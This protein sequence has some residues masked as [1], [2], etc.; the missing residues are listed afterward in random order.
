MNTNEN[1]SPERSIEII[2]EMIEKT[3]LNVA[4]SS[5][6][7]LIIWGCLTT[8]TAAAVGILWTLTGSPIWNLLWLAMMLI[9]WGYIFTTSIKGKKTKI[10]KPVTFVNKVL[11]YV[12]LTFGVSCFAIIA[13]NNIN[14]FVEGSLMM[15]YTPTIMLLMAFATTITALVLKLGNCFVF[16]GGSFIFILFS[17]WYPGS[18]EMF[19]LAMQSVFLLIIPGLIINSRVRKGLL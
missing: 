13:F 11:E 15:P 10:Q 5:G 7:P 3:R 14:S 16:I 17:M 9:G 12:W 1:L 19:C 18:Y 8:I 2:G 6:T 4:R